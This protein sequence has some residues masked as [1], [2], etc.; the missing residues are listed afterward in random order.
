LIAVAGE[1][2]TPQSLASLQSEFWNTGDQDFLARP[3]DRIYF[4]A[5][6]SSP[7]R[8]ADT[9]FVRWMFHD[10]R[11]GWKGSDRIPLR[12]TG[13]RKAGFRGFTTKQNFDYGDGSWRVSVETA[14]GR[15][16]GRT[17]FHVTRA[18]ADPGRVFTTEA[19]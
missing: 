10:A 11:S 1:L 15:E 16:I 17:Y 6:I 9:V 8:F 13:G 19:Y 3:G 18:E 2:T 12:I 7:A 4:F 14:D 5:A